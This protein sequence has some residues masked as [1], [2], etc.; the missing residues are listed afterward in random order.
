MPRLLLKIDLFL[1]RVLLAHDNSAPV[2]CI[3]LSIVTQAFEFF[4]IVDL[5]SFLVMLVDVDADADVDVDVVN[6]IGVSG[7]L[8]S[9][10]FVGSSRNCQVVSSFVQL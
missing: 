5:M 7:Y 10:A 1:Q 4:K 6:E 3:R 8:F 2:K 9:R